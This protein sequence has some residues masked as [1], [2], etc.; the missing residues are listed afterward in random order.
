LV[1]PSWLEQLRKG[2]LYLA[3]V[4]PIFCLVKYLVSY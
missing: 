1:L 4:A 3:F 2:W